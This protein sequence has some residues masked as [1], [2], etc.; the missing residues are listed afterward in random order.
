[1]RRHGFGTLACADDDGVPQATHLPMLLTPG[2]GDGKFGAL[3]FHFARPNEQGKLFEG[4]SR[5]ALAM[6]HGP[7]AY[8]SP[9]WYASAA[10]VVPTWNYLVVHARGMPRML[11]DEQLAEHLRSL[12]SAYES[13]RAQPWDTDRL[14]PDSFAKLRAAVVGFEMEITSIQGKWKLGQ[15][16]T[17]PEREGA[18]AG[19]REAGDGESLAIAEAMAA[20]LT[21]SADGGHT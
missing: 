19:L 7:H 9:T 5:P 18:I 10:P 20:A 17:R 2:R 8:I 21:A 4:D 15:N 3:Q 16:R 13:P 11:G 14:P 1:V 6:F 12:V